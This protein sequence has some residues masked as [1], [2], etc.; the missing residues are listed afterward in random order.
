[1][2]HYGIF[3][4]MSY[5][6]LSF[7]FLLQWDT[8]SNSK[9]AEI[10]LTH[11]VIAAAFSSNYACLYV[12]STNKNEVNMKVDDRV[13]KSHINPDNASVTSLPPK[14]K[15]DERLVSFYHSC[16]LKC[17]QRLLTTG[18]PHLFISNFA[19]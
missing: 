8:S 16:L 5:E 14:F 15:S 19:R 4:N 17:S 13:Y 6:C 9:V 7:F 1:M 3:L 11:R 2:V 10:R 12:A 18:Y